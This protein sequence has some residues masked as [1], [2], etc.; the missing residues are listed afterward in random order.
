MTANQTLRAA[1]V[2]VTAG[3]LLLQFAA[4]AW[5]SEDAHITFR[6]IEN[7]SDGHGLRWNVDERVQVYTHPLWLALITLA[8][9]VT[10]EFYFTITGISLALSLC[11]YL[12]LARVWRDRPLLIT[13]FVFAPLV[14]SSAVTRY[15]TSGFENPLTLFLYAVFA[16]TIL[17]AA[18]GTK[19]PLLKLALIAALAAVNRLDS[20]LLY[21]PVLCATLVR[22]PSIRA[23]KQLLLGFAPLVGWL[24]FSLFYYGFALPNTALAKLSA[25]VPR[26]VYLSKGA[27]YLADLL[28]NDPV[29]GCVLAL[30]VIVT[31]VALVRLRSQR[32]DEPSARLAW[33][34]AGIVLY[35]VYVIWIGG[36]FL[37]GRFWSAPVFASVPLC[38]AAV[39]FWG[40]FDR[41]R[42][43]QV[44]ATVATLLIAYL[45]GTHWLAGEIGNRFGGQIL[46]LSTARAMLSRDLSWRPSDAAGVFQLV[47]A[48]MRDRAAAGERVVEPYPVIGFVGLE[49]GPGVT[50]IDTNALADPLLARLP[51]METTTIKI[52]HLERALPNGY[53]KA[54]E[55]GSVEGMDPSLG[56]YYEKL[57]LIIAGPLL[58]R[59]RIETLIRFN[60]GSFDSLRSSYLERARNPGESHPAT[61]PHSP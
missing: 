40:G 18:P 39:Q 53:L 16:S 43:P 5:V 27:G 21:L 59:E 48:Q 45:V 4:N 51:P 47:G 33:L 12:M 1:V 10:G 52:G 60:L 49:A 15:A 50:L 6:T 11:A 17:R 24:L 55:T 42:S 31:V 3:I 22:T 44:A 23:C 19:V 36:D 20:I 56:E 9:A 46:P 14:M 2:P 28:R 61:E 30:A 37:S 54:R 57:R 34:G 26:A 29:S 38:A 41:L 7:F 13:L 25:E 8:H 35:S 32:D 58:D